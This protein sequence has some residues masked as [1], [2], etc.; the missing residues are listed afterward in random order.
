MIVPPKITP[1]NVPNSVALNEV[2]RLKKIKATHETKK[3]MHKQPIHSINVIQSK[4]LT[5]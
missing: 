4:N 5:F 3:P 1:I 2:S